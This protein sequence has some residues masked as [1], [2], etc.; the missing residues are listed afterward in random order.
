M[1]HFG[2][3]GLMHPTALDLGSSVAALRAGL[4]VTRMP[5]MSIVTNETQ[6]AL[7][8]LSIPRGQPRRIGW[9]QQALARL[10]VRMNKLFGPREQRAFG[11]LMYHRVA[12]PVDG[13]PTPTWNV[14]PGLFAAQL[15]GLLDLGWKP[16][17]LREALESH[18]QGKS[19]P[20]KTFVVTF[21]DGYQN[22]LTEALPILELLGVPATIFLA[23]AYLD[24]DR[25][26]PSD[27]WQ[28]A[29]DPGVPRVTWKPL[30]TDQCHE[31][32]AS[33]LIELA[34]HTH[35]HADFRGRPDE[36]IADLCLCRASL[37]QHFGIEQ[38][39]FAFPYGTKRDGF[40]G[41]ALAEAARRASM[42][43]S[44]TTEPHLV[45]PGDDPFDWGRFA[46]E[47]HDTAETL[48]AKLGGWH[49]LLRNM[50]RMAL[51]RT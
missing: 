34:A 2:R 13:F 41:G 39:T 24:S 3:G 11:I 8:T 43:C 6:L 21:D 30:T 29:G 22:N 17:P 15:T 38:P 9:R 40:A 46:A 18:L 47:D 12:E 32:A 51:G 26:F 48:A 14:P 45:R 25:P 5:L 50:G 7:P 44:L 20:R 42:A 31:L 49:T 33:G 4:L 36:F 1:V 37:R 27:D 19:L 16:V 23:T 35:T 10:A 28:S